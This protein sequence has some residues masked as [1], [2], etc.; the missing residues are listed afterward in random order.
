MRAG[1]MAMHDYAV[2][3]RDEG[4]MA[5]KSLSDAFD[6]H[7]FGNLHSFAGFDEVRRLEQ[8]FLSEDELQKYVGSVG[9][10][11]NAR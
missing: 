1:L 6:R 8:E 10:V 3:L 7:P 11:P 2:R 9:H 4:P 5:E